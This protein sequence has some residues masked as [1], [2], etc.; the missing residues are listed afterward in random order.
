MQTPVLP[1]RVVWP[2][3]FT[4]LTVSC[5]HGSSLCCT[6]QLRS[7]LSCLHVERQR[8]ALAQRSLV[9]VC[10]FAERTDTVHSGV[11]EVVASAGVS[12]SSAGAPV[13]CLG[14]SLPPVQLWAPHSP[15]PTPL[16]KRAPHRGASEPARAPVARE[17]SGP[18]LGAVSGLTLKCCPPL[19]LESLRPSGSSTS[20]RHAARGL[21][22][23]GAGPLASYLPEPKFPPLPSVHRRRQRQWPRC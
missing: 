22:R 12:A 4:A 5:G 23:G 9:P 7:F 13:Q 6:F 19:L 1:G 10:R 3:F 17:L 16:P 20:A 8:F 18:L 14:C 15:S 11:Q 2:P 21:G